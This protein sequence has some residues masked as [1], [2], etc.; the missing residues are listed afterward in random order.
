MTS[1]FKIKLEGRKSLLKLLKSRSNAK[2]TTS[3][4]LFHYSSGITKNDHKP[5]KG[6]VCYESHKQFFSYLGTVTIT[7]D[8]TAN[9]G[10]CI[11][12]TAF[13]NVV[14]FMCHTYCDTGPQFLRSFPKDP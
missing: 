9:L 7:G 11:A 14:S 5:R 4:Y 2:V 8:W 10:L 6:L 13:S 3:N 12:L 1:D